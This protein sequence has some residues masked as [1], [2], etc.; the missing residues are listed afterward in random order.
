[1]YSLF[2]QYMK[3]VSVFILSISL[4]KI[5]LIGFVFCMVGILILYII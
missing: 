2:P 3:K 4:D 1:M 5:R